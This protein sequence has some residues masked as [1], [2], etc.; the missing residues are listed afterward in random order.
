MERSI[1]IIELLRLKKTSKIIQSNYQ[2]IFS[3]KWGALWPSG[4]AQCE[5]LLAQSSVFVFF[6]LHNNAPISAIL[7]SNLNKLIRKQQN[8]PL[9]NLFLLPC[10]PTKILS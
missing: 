5:F 1:R 3:L 6:L 2:P 4:S 10:S 9:K 7:T 8:R